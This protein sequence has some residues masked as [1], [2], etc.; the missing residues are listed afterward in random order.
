MKSRF[1]FFRLGHQVLL[2]LLCGGF[3]TTVAQAQHIASPLKSA[4]GRPG[5]ASSGFLATRPQQS[6]ALAAASPDVVW[7]PC[8]PEAQ[9]LGAMCGTLPVLLD[10]QDPDGPK[11]NIYFE[12]YLHTNSGLAQSAIL[13]NTGGPGVGTTSVLRGPGLALFARNLDVHDFLLID[14]RGRGLSAAINCEELQHGTVPFWIAEAEDRK[15]VV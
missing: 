1:A 15:S 8:P 14:D 5:S 6:S 2:I 3:V 13:L 10:R 11:I 12:L 4:H 9:A 7:A